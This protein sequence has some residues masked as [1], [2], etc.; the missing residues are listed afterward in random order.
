MSDEKKDAVSK[1]GK[2]GEGSYEGTKK[3]Q[4]GFE[5]FAEDTSADEAVKK[6]GEI[7]PDDASLKKAEQRGK[8]GRTSAHSIH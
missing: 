7:N 8:D 1:S 2:G 4:E 5:K 3:Y 6:A